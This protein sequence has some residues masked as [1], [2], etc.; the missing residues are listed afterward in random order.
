MTKEVT[1]E[2]N[3]NNTKIRN[4]ISKLMC[5]SLHAASTQ[6]VKKS[7]K[8]QIIWIN[9]MQTKASGFLSGHLFINIQPHVLE[10]PLGKHKCETLGYL[11]FGLFA[12]YSFL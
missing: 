5:F 3:E 11:L 6:L 7:P 1:Q 8:C 9:V 4:F 10:P 2:T 12:A